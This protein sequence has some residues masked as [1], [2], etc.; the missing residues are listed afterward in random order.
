MLNKI[1][2]SLGFGSPKELKE[3]EE[4]IQ[5]QDTSAITAESRR[6]MM[7]LL[8]QKTQPAESQDTGVFDEQ[9]ESV[10]ENTENTQDM[11]INMFKDLMGESVSEDSQS[12][13]IDNISLL[14]Q[15]YLNI[16]LKL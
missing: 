13:V 1:K 3:K 14:L 12:K 9:Y 2:N 8:G 7:D 5:S 11:N 16:P 15:K 4:V 6:G 10:F